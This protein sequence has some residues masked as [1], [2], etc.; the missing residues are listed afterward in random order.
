MRPGRLL[1]DDRGA[2]MVEFA[3]LAPAFFLLVMGI[4]ECGLLLRA[5]HALQNAAAMAA[6]CASVDRNLCGTVTGI[7]SYAVQQSLG[8]DPPATSFTVSTPAC[9]TQITASYA[10]QPVAGFFGSVTLTAQACFPK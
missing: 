8:L 4:V 5:Q 6:R 10:V 3:L 9:G 2:S 1:A 7:R